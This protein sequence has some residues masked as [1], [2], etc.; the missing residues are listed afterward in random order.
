MMLIAFEKRKVSEL[1][2]SAIP[3][4]DEILLMIKNTKLR[5]ELDQNSQRN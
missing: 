5:Q 1:S 4:I 3:K 2:F